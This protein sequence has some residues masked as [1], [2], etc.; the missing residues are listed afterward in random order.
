MKTTFNLIISG[1]QSSGAQGQRDNLP[2]QVGEMTNNRILG[3][4]KMDW[5]DM[6]FGSAL[7]RSEEMLRQAVHS[8]IA[9]D[10]TNNEAQLPA[11]NP[12]SVIEDLLQ[13]VHSAVATDFTNNEVQLTAEN[14]SSVIED[15]LQP[16]PPSLNLVR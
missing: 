13:A 4:S 7:R 14:P 8:A 11:E 15:L 1:L 2:A 10:F 12:G 5:I 3:F 16:E 6:E 9:T